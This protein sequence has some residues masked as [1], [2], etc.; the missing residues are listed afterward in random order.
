MG[1]KAK[2]KNIHRN[3]GLPM[4]DLIKHLE[5]FKK[6]EMEK[7]EK[8]KQEEKTRKAEKRSKRRQEIK[9]KLLRWKNN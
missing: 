7:L 4:D 1:K 8:A 2:T 3:T 9:Q 6:K 5:E